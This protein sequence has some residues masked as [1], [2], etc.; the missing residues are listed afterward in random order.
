VSQANQTNRESGETAAKL[1]FLDH[2]AFPN[3]GYFW[4]GKYEVNVIKVTKHK[5]ICCSAWSWLGE[6]KIHVLSMAMLKGYRSNRDSNLGLVKKIHDLYTEADI[7]VGH[8]IDGYDDKMSNTDI[9]KNGLMPPPPHKTVDTL[10][11]ARKYFRFNGNSLQDLGQ[12]LGLGEKVPHEGFLLWEKCMA[13]NPVAWRH[14]ARYNV[15]DVSL[16]KKIYFKFRPWI[17]NHPALRVR[18]QFACPDCGGRNLQS[19]GARMT[20]TG[21]S[22]RHQC[23]DCGR[24]A[25][26]L[27]V[28][29][30]KKTAWVIK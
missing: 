19:R 12:F 27:K 25:D 23:Q 3:E 8:N 5:K 18:G 6:Q 14:M 22:P 20:R 24:W 21:K 9:V 26:S 1:L 16:L 10:K 11:V 28:V 13:G 17:V 2:E 30:R 29:V 15:G 4:H 7:I